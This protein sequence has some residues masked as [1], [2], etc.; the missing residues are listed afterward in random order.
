MILDFGHLLFVSLPI[1]LVTLACQ[2]WVKSAYAK[3]SAVPNRRGASGFEVASEILRRAGLDDVPVEE[4]RGFLSDH[5]DP[6]RRVLRLSPQNYEGRSVAAV[7]IAAHEAGHAIQHASKYAPLVVRNAA[8]PMASIGSSAG[9]LVLIL[10][11]F[12]GSSPLNWISITGLCLVGAVALFQ[13]V[14]LPVEFDAS[15]RALKL[16]PGLGILT[17][18]ETE[19]AKTMLRAA[20]MTY[21]AAT[22]AAIWELLYWL[23][24]L[25]V[26]GRSDE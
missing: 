2:A 20:A 15:A 12:I 1:L 19:G 9:Y 8:V 18:E 17:P 10:G 16:L 6:T 5:Y 22:A 25:G 11:V 13:I 24:R 21:V 4:S 26:L 23:L 14:N 7:A 3:W